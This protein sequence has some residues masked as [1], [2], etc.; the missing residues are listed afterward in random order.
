MEDILS[1]IQQIFT[2][3]LLCSGGLERPNVSDGENEA[4]SGLGKGLA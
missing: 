1:I 3:H 4:L 2:E